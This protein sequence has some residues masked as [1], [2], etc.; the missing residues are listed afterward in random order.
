MTDEMIKV[1]DAKVSDE[2]KKIVCELTKNIKA[3]NTR[4]LKT[5]EEEWQQLKN[6]MKAV[7]AQL[8]KTNSTA[9]KDCKILENKICSAMKYT[10]A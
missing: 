5:S 2:S 10:E 3:E 7:S 4:N 9:I 8:V 6:E 1:L